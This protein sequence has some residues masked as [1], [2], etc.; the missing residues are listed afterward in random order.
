ME[1]EAHW[2]QMKTLG[3]G[4]I[5]AHKHN[6]HLLECE[7]ALYT[8]L[9]PSRQGNKDSR[10]SRASVKVLLLGRWPN[11]LGHCIHVGDPDEAPGTWLQ[12]GPVLILAAFGDV[13]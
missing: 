1:P 12:L 10:V 3:W 7:A 13:N 11:Y 6:A 5:L 4:T 8:W 9:A 2:G